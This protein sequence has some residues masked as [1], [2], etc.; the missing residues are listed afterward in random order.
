MVSAKSSLKTS[1]IRRL[2]V[3]RRVYDVPGNQPRAG[4]QLQ[5]G[6]APHCGAEKLAHLSIGRRVLAQEAVVD[7][8][9]PVPEIRFST[10]LRL[11]SSILLKSSNLQIQ[12]D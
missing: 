2:D 8:C 9:M 10:S 4:G 6:P 5:H 7:L 1:S 3:R 12:V 11:S